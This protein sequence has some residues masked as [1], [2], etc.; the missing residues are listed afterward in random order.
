MYK[1][2]LAGCSSYATID[3]EL[4][5]MYGCDCTMASGGAGGAGG[6]SRGSADE[7]ATIK[8]MK[9]VFVAAVLGGM[10]V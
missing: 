4:K 8:P 1:S 9:L 2:C 5:F 7:G 10:M 6:A 3:E